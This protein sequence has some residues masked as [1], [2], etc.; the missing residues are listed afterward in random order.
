MIPRRGGFGL[1]GG[2]SVRPA[3]RNGIQPARSTNLAEG[4]RY[5]QARP[6]RMSESVRK[7]RRMNRDTIRPG[8][9]VR[10]Y[11]EILRREGNWQHL[12]EGTVVEV[13]PEK[14]GSWFVHG[15]DTRLW[16]N[17]VY[18]RK[19]DGEL[20][21]VAVDPYTRFEILAENSA[22]QGAATGGAGA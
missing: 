2:G 10:V 5:V 4:G 7:Y 14:T 16:L 8:Q 9:R 1:S 20:T 17:R 3:G 19:D 6:C 21:S 13:R 18:L 12:V 15:K 22:T 11:Q